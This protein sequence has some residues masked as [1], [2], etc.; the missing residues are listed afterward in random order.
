[1]EKYHL[2]PD[3]NEFNFR[4][5]FGTSNEKDRHYNTPR[6]WYGQRYL[7]PEMVQSPTSADMPFI[8]KANRKIKLQMSNLF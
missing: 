5:I 2:N 4:H 6:V 8:C 7:T 3:E 1:M